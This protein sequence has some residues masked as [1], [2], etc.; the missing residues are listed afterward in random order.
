[1][2]INLLVADDDD[3][4]R[5][6]L[7]DILTK[8]RY[9]VLD[10]KN[11]KEALD[12]FYKNSSDIDLV[13]LDV[14]MP[15]INGWEAAKEIRQHSEVP[16]MMLTALGDESSEI[17][18]LTSGADDYLAKPFSYGVFLARVLSL[19]RKARKQKN[20]IIKANEITI[21]Q[22]EYKA[23]IGEQELI[24][25]NKEYQLLVYLLTNKNILLTREQII[26]N[27]WGYDFDGDIRTVDTH[28][29]TLRAKLGSAGCYIETVRGSGYRFRESEK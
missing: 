2:T 21:M 9:C 25:S 3:R 6:M 5:E 19:T 12:I 1:M 7:V 11:G 27:I 17:K 13:I 23:Y 10:A 28:I 14:M 22:G 20:A 15:E 16:I 24:L 26:R 18:G 8:N 4:F 29:K